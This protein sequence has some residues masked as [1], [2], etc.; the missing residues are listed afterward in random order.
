M[1]SHFNFSYHGR[2]HILDVADDA[3]HNSDVFPARL[4]QSLARF[5]E[6][7]SQAN[8]ATRVERCTFVHEENAVQLI[9]L[10][11]RSTLT[12]SIRNRESGFCGKPSIQAHADSVIRLR[13]L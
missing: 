12:T 3:N 8:N 2:A 6:D 7:C 9:G 5:C 4:A 13:S 11:D 10:R 1:M